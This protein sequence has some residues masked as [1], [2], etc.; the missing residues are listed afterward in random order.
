MNRRLRIIAIAALAFVSLSATAS[1]TIPAIEHASLWHSVLR[2]HELNPAL[3]GQS[4][5]TSFSSASATLDVTTL[6]KPI[7]Q[8]L[9]DDSRRWSLAAESFLRLSRRLSVWGYASYGSG[10][11]DNV[12]WNSSSDFLLMYPYVMAD[13]LGGNVEQEQYTF[14]GGFS[15]AIGESWKLGASMSLRAGHE[16]RKRDPRMRGIVTDMTL[17]VGATRALGSYEMGLSAMARFYKQTNDVV[18]MREEGVIPEYHMTG[19]GADYTRFSGSNRS[20]H[21]QGT[22][23]GAALSLTPAAD[24]GFYLSAALSDQPYHQILTDLNAL[25]L[26]DLYVTTLSGEAGWKHSIGRRRIAFWAAA[27]H[28]HRQGDELMAGSSSASE[29]EELGHLTLFRSNLTRIYGA[30][31]CT[32]QNRNILTA[33]VKAGYIA[34]DAR[35]EQPARRMEINKTFAQGQLQWQRRFGLY[36]LSAKADAMY[37]MDTHH[38]L[39]LPVAL[40]NE[41]VLGLVSYNFDMLSKDAVSAGINLR[42]DRRLGKSGNMGCFAEMDGRWASNLDNDNGLTLALS[43]GVTF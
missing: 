6:Q 4:F 34:A 42:A 22:G 2:H 17:S 40:M 30:A 35:Y 7:V 43:L 13:T 25:P 37:L 16:Y 5:Q 31:A 36:A 23:F 24:E 20:L 9:G 21:F 3:K 39:Q 19:L 26:T 38:E 28:E 14:G 41:A 1:D 15:T 10:R 12:K 27:D 18:F 33:I 11:T 29:Y 32:W 8:Q